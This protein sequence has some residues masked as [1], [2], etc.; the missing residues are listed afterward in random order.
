MKTFALTLAALLVASSASVDA[1]TVDDL[2]LQ[3]LALCQDSWLAWEN[4]T[5][6][7]ARFTDDF[8]T[9]FGRSASDDAGFTPKSPTSVLG[10]PVTQVYPESVGMGVGFSMTVNA[11]H[12]RVRAGVERQLGRPMACE[13]SEGVR[14]CQ[15]E[16][17]AKKTVVLMTDQ[18][19]RAQSSLVGCYYFYRQ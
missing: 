4:D 6:R 18:N 2:Q 10:W 16:L 15:V 12:A 19:G 5:A 8:K 3:R 14:S 13:T 7:A 9:R 11:D 1:G 17:G